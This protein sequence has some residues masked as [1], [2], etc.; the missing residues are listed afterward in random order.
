MTTLAKLAISVASLPAIMLTVAA[1]LELV[2]GEEPFSGTVSVI[3]LVV[4][5]PVLVLVCRR[6]R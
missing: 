6:P 3:T 4:L 1:A 2:T 5:L